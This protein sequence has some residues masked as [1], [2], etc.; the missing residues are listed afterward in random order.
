MTCVLP[1]PLPCSA[2]RG[3]PG[4]ARD[5]VNACDIAEK[6]VA[7]GTPL[8][9]L[10]R[11]GRCYHRGRQQGGKG[12]GGCSCPPSP[13][14]PEALRLSA[15]SG[16]P[17]PPPVRAPA[18]PRGGGG[19]VFPTH[20]GVLCTRPQR[21]GG[22]GKRQSGRWRR[23]ATAGTGATQGRL[24]GGSGGGSGGTRHACRTREDAAAPATAAT[25]PV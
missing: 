20:G 11:R 24:A 13:M 25:W 10:R 8:P 21:A 14:S 9:G 18:G 22:L 2:V 16:R 19:A 17:P 6:K 12:G 3:E 23:P 5:A 15:R 4:G 7:H 1:A